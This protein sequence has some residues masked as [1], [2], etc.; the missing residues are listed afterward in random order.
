MHLMNA[1]RF[2][3]LSGSS[4][5]LAGGAYLLDTA[6]DAAVPLASPGL[7]ALVPVF[8]LI[9]FTGVWKSLENEGQGVFGLL[10]YA[11]A[12]AGL[13]GLVV[14]TFLFNRLAPDLSPDALGAVLNGVRAELVVIGMVFLISAV[15][16]CILAWKADRAKRIGALAYAI[17]A[18][19]VALPPLFPVAIVTVGGISVSLGLLAWGVS[20]LVGAKGMKRHSSALNA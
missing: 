7:G 10:T 11:L 16:V 19:P 15:L 8:G 9:G 17:G 6:L 1:S 18:I 14:V 4:L 12:M 2:Q 13:S 5:C 3:I 20:M